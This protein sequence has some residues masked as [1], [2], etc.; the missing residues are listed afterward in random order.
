M[1]IDMHYV[2]TGIVHITWKDK[3]T[4]EEVEERTQTLIGLADEHGDSAYVEIIDLSRCTQVPF[5]LRGLQRAAKVD[6]RVIGF[7]VIQ[8]SQAAKVMT[9]ML[10]QLTHLSF[11][12]V[13]A[14]DEAL[15]AAR[16]ILQ[17]S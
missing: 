7:V 5:D 3:V 2:E 1:P 12:L 6:S 11:R 16:E 4:L 8:P 17:G 15:V 14:Y 9:N 10:R 13:N